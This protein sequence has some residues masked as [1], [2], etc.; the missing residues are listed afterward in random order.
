MGNPP[1]VVN[2]FVDAMMFPCA[3]MRKSEIVEPT[4]V[5]PDNDQVRPSGKARVGTAPS[6]IVDLRIGGDRPRD[7]SIDPFGGAVVGIAT[8]HDPGVEIK[9]EN[10]I[11]AQPNSRWERWRVVLDGEGMIL[12]TIFFGQV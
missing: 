9:N 5:S 12:R 6:K 2:L 3:E 4:Q 7:G 1:P 8:D 10:R 11:A